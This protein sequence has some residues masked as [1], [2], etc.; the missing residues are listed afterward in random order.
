MAQDFYDAFG[1]GGSNKHIGT[2]DADG[3]ALAAIQALHQIVEERD[4]E[5][6]TLRSESAAMRARIES[7]ERTVAELAHAEKGGK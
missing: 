2:I 3:V 5:I 1:L 4:T 6:A 7:L